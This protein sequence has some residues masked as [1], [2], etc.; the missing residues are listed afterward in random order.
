MAHRIPDAIR[1]GTII[2]V[3][4]EAPCLYASVPPVRQPH[5]NFCLTATKIR[6]YF[7]MSAEHELRGSCTKCCK[8]YVAWEAR[9]LP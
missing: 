8:I 2:A 3:K 7:D 1:S 4:I 9:Y 5:Q 6:W